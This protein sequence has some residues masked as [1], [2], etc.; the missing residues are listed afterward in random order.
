M[1]D[2]SI[3]FRNNFN[4]TVSDST[5]STYI[6]YGKNFQDWAMAQSLNDE[7]KESLDKWSI[8]K[9]DYYIPLIFCNDLFFSLFLSF[10]FHDAKEKSI[11]VYPHCR[12]VHAFLAHSLKRN[13]LEPFVGTKESSP[14]VYPKTERIWASMQRSNE[15]SHYDP[16][17]EN[18]FLSLKETNMVRNREFDIENIEEVQK[19]LIFIL[20]IFGSCRPETMKRL[21][22][23]YCKSWELNIDGCVRKRAECSCI[24]IKSNQTGMPSYPQIKTKPFDFLVVVQ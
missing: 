7:Q 12:K 9:T 20:N 14:S 21:N 13:N 4:K 5:I 3:D 2:K 19:Q 22:Y 23:S 18:N 1:A 16:I 15:F 17:R 6:S 11:A 8:S 10:T 24:I